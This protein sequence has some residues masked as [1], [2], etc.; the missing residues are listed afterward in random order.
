MSIVVDLPAP[1]GPSSATVSPSSIETSMPRTASTEPNDFVRPRSVTPTPA[2]T[3]AVVCSRA[4]TTRSS[5]RNGCG[6]RQT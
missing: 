1:F 6:P 2:G 5:C 3:T 4:V